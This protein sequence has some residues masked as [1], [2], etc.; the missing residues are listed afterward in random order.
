M[1][2][3]S[4]TQSTETLNKAVCAVGRNHQFVGAWANGIPRVGGPAEL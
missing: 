3:L 2:L 4:W 1:K